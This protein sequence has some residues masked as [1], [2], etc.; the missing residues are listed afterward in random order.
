[1]RVQERVRLMRK[2]CRV[3]G[4]IFRSWRT[5]LDLSHLLAGLVCCPELKSWLMSY[6]NSVL[7]EYAQNRILRIYPALILCTFISVVCVYL[8]GYLSSQGVKFGEL[9][10]WVAGQISFVQFYNP[11]FMRAF[12]VSVLNGSLWSIT[13][14]LQFYI[15]LNQI[16][17]LLLFFHRTESTFH[18]H[19]HKRFRLHESG[20]RL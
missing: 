4:E 5:S 13:V 15:L 6:N 20:S 10:L 17:M 14:E 9:I 3:P 19:F 2:F 12:G 11:D 8:T 1:M 16:E 7:K 18:L